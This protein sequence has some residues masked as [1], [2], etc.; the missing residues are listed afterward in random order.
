[1]TTTETGQAVDDGAAIEQ[2]AERLFLEGVGATHLFNAYL[3]VR[4]GLFKAIDEH[5]SSTTADLAKATA[6]DEWYVREWLQAETIAG[7]VVADDEDLRTAH[8]TL[9]PGV[10]QT[11]IAETNPAYVGGL[12]YVLPAIGRGMPD[13]VDAF[14]TGAG[15]PYAAYGPE[16]IE[17]QAAMNRPAFVN[18]LAASWLPAMPDVDARLRDADR[19]G[20]VADV[21]CGFGWAAIELAKAYPHVRV[22]GFDVDEQSIAQARRNA[23]EHGVDDRVTFEVVDASATTYGG[24][25]YDLVMFLECLHDIGR[26]VEALAT[27][28]ESV[29]DDGVVLVMD[30][31]V[32]ETRPPAGDPIEMFMATVSVLWCLPQSRVVADCEA[33][34]TVMR[35]STLEGIAKR[36]GWA[37]FEVLDI[38]HPFWRFYRLVP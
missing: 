27:A 33:P 7:L 30:E 21:G 35:P 5:P 4:L 37:G 26:P 19:P 18:D 10:V 15:V 24:R 2:L 36:A 23:R 22:D 14:R 6:L 31:R 16:A 34:G 28:R 38:E 17:A 3:G 32:A 25:E 8:F 11:Q 13:L 20:S 29:A 9:A 12:P 1:M